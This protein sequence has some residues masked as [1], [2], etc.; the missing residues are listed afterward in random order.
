MEVAHFYNAYWSGLVGFFRAR[1][2][3]GDLNLV[4][5]IPMNAAIVCAQFIFWLE[6]VRNG[7]QWIS[8]KSIMLASRF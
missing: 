6:M 1:R 8:R 3:R 7:F 2:I 5:Q 4:T